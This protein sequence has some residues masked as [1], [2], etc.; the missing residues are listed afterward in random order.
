MEGAAFLKALISSTLKI[1]IAEAL[2]AISMKER[3]GC[4]TVYVEEANTFET[5][6]PVRQTPP[7]L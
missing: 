5:S 3:V 6:V 2:R 1:L 7:W 4:Y